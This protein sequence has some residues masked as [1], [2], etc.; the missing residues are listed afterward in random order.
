[1]TPSKISRGDWGFTTTLGKAPRGNRDV[2]VDFEVQ[3][4]KKLLKKP[5]ENFLGYERNYPG[6]I[7]MVV[8][9]ENA[10]LPVC[11]HCGSSD[12]AEVSSGIVSQSIHLASATTKFKLHTNPPGRYFCNVCEE[13]FSP[14][15]GAS[16]KWWEEIIGDDEI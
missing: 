16:P 1:L 7:A 11:A 6:F 2:L 5:L 14:A 9:Y 12:T 15:D 8:Q 10:I 3:R 4:K 13:Y